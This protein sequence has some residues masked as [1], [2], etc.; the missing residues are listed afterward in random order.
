MR[1]GRDGLSLTGCRYRVHVQLQSNDYNAVIP[2]LNLRLASGASR[3]RCSP[4]RMSTNV[5]PPA[6]MSRIDTWP[7]LGS[8]LNDPRALTTQ[9]DHVL[10]VPPH[11]RRT[12]RRNVGP[13]SPSSALREMSINSP[14]G[15]LRV[16][17]SKGARSSPYNKGATGSRHSQRLLNMGGS[18]SAGFFDDGE[19]LLASGGMNSSM[20]VADK[21]VI[22]KKAAGGGPVGVTFREDASLGGTGVLLT[23]IDPG[24]PAAS[25]TLFVG[26]VITQIDGHPVK[27]ADEAA[28]RAPAALAACLLSARTR[29]VV[30][31]LSPHTLFAK[32]A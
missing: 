13:D 26:D 3:G 4:T 2:S 10:V 29:T 20:F 12:A 23:H 30:T 16:A 1:G 19:L 6:N 25:S 11:Y 9:I 32:L 17:K 27:G 28:K 8:C 31:A 15:P 21:H 22:L 24:S 7:C 18:D 14:S 5:P